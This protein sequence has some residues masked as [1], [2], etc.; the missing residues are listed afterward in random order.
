M[1]DFILTT[2]NLTK[3]Y[4][5]TTVLKDINLSLKRGEIYALIG[6]NGAG[7]TTLMRII[8]GL[9]FKTSGDFTLF[10][11]NNYSHMKNQKYRIGCIIEQPALYL[12]MNAYD[13]MNITRIQKGIPDTS[14][15]NELL[16]LVGLDIDNKK[17]TK[18][19]SMGMKQRLSIA[20]SLLGSPEFLV[21]DEPINGLDPRGIMDI[22]NILI[23]ISKKE[24]VTILISSHNL[25]ELYKTATNFIILNKGKV[26]EM[27]TDA[28]LDEKCKKHI[29]ISSTDINKLATTLEQKLNTTNFKVINKTDVKLYDYLNDIQ[30]VTKIMV[31]ENIML[32]NISINQDSLEEYYIKVMEG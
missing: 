8:L 25:E 21:L 15:I 29:L 13:N 4:Q 18:T 16:A 17:K 20:L 14:K 31:E 28:E 27:M 7:K 23:S 30:S 10:G 26:K 11:E 1:S 3:V 5:G 24:N 2:N 22:R 9:A 6:E 32:T 19:Y 12:N